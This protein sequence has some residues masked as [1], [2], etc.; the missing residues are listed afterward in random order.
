MDIKAYIESGILELYVMESLSPAE[1]REVE[2]L[3]AQYPEIKAEI[4]SIQH[5][6]NQYALLHAKAPRTELKQQILEKIEAPQKRRSARFLLLALLLGIL[7]ILFFIYKWWNT[8]EKLQRVVAENQELKVLNK[9]AA[10]QLA[11]LEDPNTRAIVLESDKN[12]D[13]KVI[14][15]WNKAQSETLANIKSLRQPAAD[16]QFQLWAIVNGNPKDAGLLNNEKF[17]LQQMKDIAEAD[18]FAITLEPAGGSSMPTSEI[19]IL[20]SI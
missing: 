18:A 13:E 19:I 7:I 11:F 1:S 6:L 5:A 16:K 17:S 3:A 4:E 14:I 20:G 15:Y 2:T 10:Q 8:S 12:P 9:N